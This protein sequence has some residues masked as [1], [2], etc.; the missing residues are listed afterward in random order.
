VAEL[1]DMIAR[2]RALGRAARTAVPEI[3][4]ECK[5]IVAEN[6]RAQRGPDGE[7]WPR[8]KDGAP[9]LE[10]AADALS[11]QG[12]NGAALLTLSGPEA[13][14]HLGIARGRV[15]RRILPTKGIPAPMAEAIKRVLLRRLDGVA[16]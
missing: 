6:I 11:A 1:D 7:A 9:V 8:A 4:R 5:S 3:A 14:H 13:R 10:G 16:K 2:L 12:V 15:Q